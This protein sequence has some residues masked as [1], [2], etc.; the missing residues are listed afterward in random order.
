MP[1]RRHNFPNMTPVTSIP[2]PA[3]P[4]TFQFRDIASPLYLKFDVCDPE[5]ALTHCKWV[6]FNT[7]NPR[8]LH[9]KL[10]D[11]SELTNYL[12]CDFFIFC[13]KLC[14]FCF[15]PYCF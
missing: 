6:D 15:F 5:V 7:P 2:S 1:W 4:A 8:M 3:R 14:G 11:T 10:L 12:L 13:K 9:H